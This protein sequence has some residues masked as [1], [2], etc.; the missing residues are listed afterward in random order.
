[1]YGI[2]AIDENTLAVQTPYN[3]AFNAAAKSKLGGRFQNGAWVFDARDHEA[4]RTLV[5]DHYGFVD[6]EALC[7]VRVTLAE[8]LTAARGPVIRLGRVLA[9]A[10]G[11]DTG[12]RLG[13]GV[14]LSAGFVRSGGS[15]INW[16]TRIDADTELVVHDVPVRMARRY[17]PATPKRGI[18]V[19]ILEA[20]TAPADRA[21]LEAERE[22]LLSR[23]AEIETTLIAA[24]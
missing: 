8:E 9:T 4:V 6:G 3:P 12:A 2:C 19:E 13:E 24:C 11:R 14:R 17:D 10:R 21:A 18:T 5:D 22:K 23:I 1:M 7:S 16:L 20:V 15:S